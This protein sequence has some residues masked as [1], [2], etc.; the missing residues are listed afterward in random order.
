MK[1]GIGMTV[2][3]KDLKTDNSRLPASFAPP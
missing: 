3:D 1:L 2:R